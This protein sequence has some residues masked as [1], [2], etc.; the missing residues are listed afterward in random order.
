MKKLLFVILAVFTLQASAQVGKVLKDSTSGYLYETVEGDPLKTRKYVLKNGLSVLMT[1]NRTAPKIYTCIAIKAGSKHDPKN[2]TGLAH[3]LEH[4]LFKGTD[5][6]GTRQ[7]EREKVVLE[8]IAQLYEDYN[9]VKDEKKRKRIYREID[10]LSGVA[11]KM[12]IP[13]EYDKMMQHIGAKGTNAY[14]S[15]DETVYINEIPSNQVDAWL[16]IEAERFRNPV[17]RLFHTELEAVYEE[18]NISLDS[19]FDRVF[20]TL[21]ASLFKKHSYGTQTTIG[22]IEH[23]KNPSLK[24][25][26]EYFDR[27]YVP[28]NM[29]IVLA[30]NFDPDDMIKKVD[31]AFKSYEFKPVKPI[32]FQEEVADTSAEIIKI[33]GL[34]EPSVFVGYRLPRATNENLAYLTAVRELLLNENAGLF[35]QNL[36]KKQKLLSADGDLLLMHDYSLLLF[37]GE[38]ANNQSLEEVKSLLVSQIDSLKKGKFDDKSLKSI[39]LNLENIEVKEMESNS[40]RAFNLVNLFVKDLSLSDAVLSKEKLRKISKSDL[41]LFVRN[42]FNKDFAVVMKEQVAE[43]PTEK[44]T[45][46]EITPIEVNRKDNSRFAKDIYDDVIKPIKPQFLDF[47]KDIS[48]SEFM[49]GVEL[50]QVKNKENQL[51]KL[52]YTFEMGRLNNLKLP[53]ALELLKLSGTSNLTPEG[54]GIEFFNLAC[55]FTA[56]AGDRV[57]IIEISGPE[58]SFERALSTVEHILSK[59]KPNEKV[60]EQLVSDQLKSRENAK[61]SQQAIR[62]ALNDFALYGEDNP[63]RY[64][65]SNKQLKKISV[66]E[67]TGIINSLTS[68][69]HTI[70][71]YGILEEAEVKRLLT[72]YHKPASPVILDVPV[73]KQFAIKDQKKKQVYFTDF[74]MVQAE[75]SWMAKHAGLDT[76]KL[77]N[78]ALFNE[79]FGGG[80]SSVVFQEIR[81]SKALAYSSYGYFRFPQFLDQPSMAGA[82]IGTQADKLDSAMLAMNNLILKMPESES[83]FNASLSALK[84]QISS[85]RTMP[86]DFAATYLS[87]KRQGLNIDSRKIIYPVLNNLTLKDVSDFHTST[88]AQGKF[89]VTVVGSSKRIPKKTLEKYGE[90]K[91]LKSKKIFGY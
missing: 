77:A 45:K 41:V 86:G 61:F 66:E 20:E 47:N 18:K 23:L 73:L 80:M 7:Y 76:N 19:D 34:Q 24:A 38:P 43:L 15:F 8:Q 30:G 89:V 88:F 70:S 51:F 53:L 75:I 59:V 29:G 28:N 54:V 22:T 16:K 83:L 82:Y 13:N 32:R 40:G 78:S 12:A 85:D 10:S 2:N 72:K 3:Y 60:L 69:K 58:Q 31:D 87:A 62:K 90:V 1:V 25:I 49:S 9:V 46:P 35:Q 52:R 42:N 17:L 11:A 56:Y 68:F 36:T 44:I 84:S 81:E 65:L 50:L 79:Y 27:Y 6:F 4:M 63:T 57:T 5:K 39:L 67:L 71:Y 26:Q 91:V 74:N 21:M 37:M 55:D 33:N 64:A 48:K 14:T